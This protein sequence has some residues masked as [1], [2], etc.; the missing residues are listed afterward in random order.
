MC[1]EILDTVGYG[2]FTV[3]FRMLKGNIRYSR[4]TVVYEELNRKI[5]ADLDYGILSYPKITGSSSSLTTINRAPPLSPYPIDL[6]LEVIDGS[7]Q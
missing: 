4:I 7:S 2:R 3:V 6:S 1:R 5:W